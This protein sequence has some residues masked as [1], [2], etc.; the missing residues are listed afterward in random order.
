[1]S[2]NWNALADKADDPEKAIDDFMRGINNDLGQVKAETAAVLAEERRAKRVW[3]ECAA[4]SRKLQSYAEKSLQDGNEEGA[5]RFLERKA[6]LAGKEAELKAAYEQAA[7]NAANLKQIQDKLAA[8]M[9]RL[10]ARQAQLKGKMAAAKAQ[11]RKN[12]MS[13]P[14][15]GGVE[16]SFKVLEDKADLAYNEAMA[17]A[18]LRADKKK[19]DLDELL[20]ELDKNTGKNNGGT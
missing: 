14:L 15:G 8:D 20:A 18:E 19:D 17:I 16:D 5:A 10:E 1:M 3:D 9:E 4:E 11:Q 7:T 6:A 2:S 13:S 12:S